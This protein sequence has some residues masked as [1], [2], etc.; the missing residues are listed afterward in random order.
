[1]RVRIS[2]LA[3]LFSSSSTVIHDSLPFVPELPL[4][5]RSGLR[6][7]NTCSTLA[8]RSSR[9]SPAVT[10]LDQVLA[11]AAPAEIIIGFAR[12]YYDEDDTGQTT[13]ID[14]L[15]PHTYYIGNRAVL[16]WAGPGRAGAW[17]GRAGWS[18]GLG[19]AGQM[20]T[21]RPGVTKIE[22]E[23]HIILNAACIAVAV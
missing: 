17:S 5:R 10:A 7:T 16:D 3:V 18:R 22:F 12:V 20:E 11:R 15:T 1:M 6:P 23:T 14:R 8:H 4:I 19:C 21:G 9:S 13:T 2:T